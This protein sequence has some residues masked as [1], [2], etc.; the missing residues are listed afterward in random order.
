MHSLYMRESVPLHNRAGV[1]VPLHS[2]YGTRKGLG[3]IDSILGFGS[4]IAGGIFGS[5]SEKR[6]LEAQKQM[7]ELQAKS[8]WLIANKAADV[9]NSEIRAAADT[10]RLQA[11]AQLIAIQSQHAADISALNAQK[12]VARQQLTSELY[13]ATTSGVFSLAQTSVEQAG[14]VATAFPKTATMA[15]T[16]MVLGTLGFLA[17]TYRPEPKRR[18]RRFSFGGSKGAKAE[19]SVSAGEGSI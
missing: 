2:P 8:N 3:F 9:K 16:L 12:S 4:A 5:Q 14:R 17:W 10:A 15:G 6:Q 19:T 13:G 11:E 1:V 18:R 7:A